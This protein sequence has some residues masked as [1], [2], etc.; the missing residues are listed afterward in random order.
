MFSTTVTV[1][2][3]GLMVSCSLSVI[4]LDE[5]T[6]IVALAPEASDP[7]AGEMLRFAAAEM[8]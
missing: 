1:W 7:D 8:E 6:V 5:V 2:P 3:P 4:R